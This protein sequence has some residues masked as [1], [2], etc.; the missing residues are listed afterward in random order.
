MDGRKGHDGQN[1]EIV[2]IKTVS[3]PE[4]FHLQPE[5]ATIKVS[6]VKECKNLEAI[7]ELFRAEIQKEKKA[8]ATTIPKLVAV[9]KEKPTKA[10]KS[11]QPKTSSVDLAVA[12]GGG[13]AS[14]IVVPSVV[15]NESH[16]SQGESEYIEIAL[17]DE[18]DDEPSI[19]I[20]PRRPVAAVS[21]T[22]LS[23]EVILAITQMASKYNMQ[24]S[25]DLGQFEAELRAQFGKGQ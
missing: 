7:Y 9:Q 23:D 10:L 13:V 19:S 6:V 12:G 17:V 5:P 1:D 21:K 18:L 8:I 24:S 14:A 11:K 2:I 22:L 4:T 25:S 16:K 20:S 3:T 15:A